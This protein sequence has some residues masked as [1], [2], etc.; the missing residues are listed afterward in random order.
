MTPRRDVR[1]GV[2]A[3]LLG[4]SV[5]WDGAHKRDAFVAEVLAREVTIV[6]V[7]PEVELGLGVPR[8]PIQLERRSG[9]V[10]LVGIESRRDL[11][12]AMRRYAGERVSELERLGLSGYVLKEKSPSCGLERAK[13]LEETGEWTVGVR[14]AFAA[15]LLERFPGL[16]IITEDGLADPEARARFLERVLAFRPPEGGAK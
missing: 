1:V 8:E 14:G 5:R 9:A 16:P 11:T 13:V 2:S 10:H 3:C 15:V 6:P 7:C 4:E 12:E